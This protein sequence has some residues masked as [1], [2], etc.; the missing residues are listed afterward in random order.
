M[1]LST[2]SVL[3]LFIL[4]AVVCDTLLAEAWDQAIR[5]NGDVDTLGAA[6]RWLRHG[7][8]ASLTGCGVSAVILLKE[9]ME[10]TD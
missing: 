8:H 10:V 2:L 6:I 3:A 1:K 9:A 7:L 4:I 5:T